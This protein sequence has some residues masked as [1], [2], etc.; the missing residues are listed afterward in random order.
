MAQVDLGNVGASEISAYDWRSRR[1]FVVNNDGAS[2]IEVLDL[3]AFPVVN[4]LPSIN[5]GTL[6]AA[7]SVAAHDGLLAVALEAPTKTD[8]GQV[9]FYDAE[10]LTI[11]R[12][13]T[14]GPL[15]DM[16]TFS[17]DG[18]LAITANEGEPNDAYTIDPAGSV[19][20]INVADFTVTT[21]DF[22]GFANQQTELVRNGF[23]VF[24]PT[25]FAQN[26]E[27]EYV[28]VSDDSNTAWV[29]LQENNGIARVDLTARRITGL[30]ALG[31]KDFNQTANAIDPS[32]RDSRIALATWPVRG[33]YQPDAI[34]F[35]TTNNQPYLITANEGDAR[36]YAGYTE[37]RRL[38]ALTLD[39]ARF[40]N[41]ATLRADASLGRLN[42][43]TA[44]GN[45]DADPELEEIYVVGSRSFSIWDAA[46]GNLV[47]D[48]GRQLEERAIAANLYDDARSDDKGVEPEAVTVA[49]INNRPI[50]FVGMERAD[51]VAVYDVSNPTAPTL[52]QMLPSGDA[53]EGA[54]LVRATQSP[55]QKSLLIISSEGDGTVRF[56]QPDNL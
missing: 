37:N 46:N 56:Y 12:Q 27:P 53:P 47:Y 39:P 16:V 9:V 5:L 45:T 28:A 19:S 55:N 3:S 49:R 7:N 52:L 35:F 25:G 29:T 18:R 33:H 38:S 32:D 20:I 51:A 34:A 8:N 6:G 10:R 24:G 40:P 4:R 1:L 42:V 17:P 14:V 22:A 44:V 15:P 41:A 2:R 36:E 50:A 31:T 26:I 13:V 23:K 21:L 30:F 48:C 54:L 43:S 11:T